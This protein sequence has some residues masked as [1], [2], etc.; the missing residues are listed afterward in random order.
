M[1]SAISTANGSW[2]RSCE[3]FFLPVKAISATIIGLSCEGKSVLLKLLIGLLH[4]ES[5]KEKVDGQDIAVM[6]ENDQIRVNRQF[7]MPFQGAA[8]L[9]SLTVFGNLALP[10]EPNHYLPAETIAKRV[11]LVLAEV[12]LTGVDDQYPDKLSRGMKKRGDLTRE[13]IMEPK[14]IL[15]D[16][17]PRD[18]TPSLTG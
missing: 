18:L 1:K 7:D 3:H 9:D 4:P 5:G 16:E 17:Q 13:R 8:R 11:H 15:F 12:G 6:S 14:I 10:L 2:R